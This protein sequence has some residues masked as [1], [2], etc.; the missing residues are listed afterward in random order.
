MTETIQ[1]PI[2]VIDALLP[3]LNEF[4]GEAESRELRVAAKLLLVALEQF[5]RHGGRDW[6]SLV[7]EFVDL[8]RLDPD[9]FARIMQSSRSGQRAEVLPMLF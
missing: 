4:Y 5:Q 3:R 2:E 9:K 8:A 6:S 7:Q 1:T